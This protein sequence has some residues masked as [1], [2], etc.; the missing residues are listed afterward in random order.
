MAI[1]ITPDK[2]DVK[3][4]VELYRLFLYNDARLK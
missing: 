3:N 2:S 4:Y 1:N